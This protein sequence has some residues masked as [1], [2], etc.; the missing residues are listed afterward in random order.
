MIT[1]KNGKP[2]AMNWN[3]LPKTAALA[4][5]TIRGTDQNYKIIALLAVCDT[6]RGAIR[7]AE[8]WDR[9]PKLEGH[10]VRICVKR[11]AKTTWAELIQKAPHLGPI[12]DPSD[13]KD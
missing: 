9:F 12:F 6:V 8:K 11:Q 4:V 10:H 3:T 13:G 1:E 2:A 7:C 5:V